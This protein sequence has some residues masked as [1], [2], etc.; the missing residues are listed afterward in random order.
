MASWASRLAA[1]VVA[2][3]L[4]GC[5]TVPTS[6]PVQQHTPEQPKVNAGVVVAP[7]PP[8]PGASPM[9][10]VEGF[11]H[12]M[13]TYQPG[14]DVARAYLTE[15]ASEDWH[16]ESGVQVYADGYPPTQADET[17]VLVAPVTGA[18]DGRGSYTVASGQL[19]HD[20]GL[21][22]DATGEWRISRPP[23][24]L[25]V[26]RYLFESSFVATDL[27]YFDTTGSNLVPDPR[28]YPTGERT[29]GA[30]LEGQLAGPSEWLAPAILTPPAAITLEAVSLDRQGIA[31]V[32]LGAAA[33]ALRA[34]EREQLLAE[35]VHTSTGVEGVLGVRVRTEGEYWTVPPGGDPV[36]RVG[37]FAW[38]APVDPEAPRELF[39]VT[40]GQLQRIN[41]GPRGVEFIPMAP[42]LAPVEAVSVRAD[43]AQVAAIIAG[44]TRL[45]T[46]PVA[47]GDTDVVY[48]GSSLLRPQY[49]RNGE[50][51]SAGASGARSFRVVVDATARP[52][53]LD[54]IPAGPLVAFRISPDGS[55]MALVSRD[56]DAAVLG[57]ALIVRGDDGPR[58]EGWRP[59]TLATG[60]GAV[61]KVLDVGWS[62]AS[63]LLVL[64]SGAGGATSVIL[65]DQDSAKMSDIG[66]ND[67]SDLVELTVTPG[68]P[69]LVRSA[70]GA[71]Y[72]FNGDF[73]WGLSMT[74]VDAV[75]YSG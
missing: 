65:V 42:G 10:V 52:V 21:I 8:P 49:A 54:A 9:L 62:S 68:R 37:S 4:A 15:T 31:D 35:I 74:D 67:S 43:V 1:G 23:T 32:T 6:G 59:V 45:Q 38:A 69:A 70:G 20:F 60:G 27:H 11:L 71:I 73:N 66:P 57:L 55:R 72:R 47:I 16:P 56:G 50:L 24:G 40:D 18:L 7:V 29:L 19:R 2:A 75:A 3:L 64:V 33:E 53:P 51:W 14:Y 34:P 25:L 58:L 28:Y 48:T 30:A 17:V 22:K 63:E 13:A 46:S 12:A 39:A 26:S 61:G 44:G 36:L 5:A 41:E